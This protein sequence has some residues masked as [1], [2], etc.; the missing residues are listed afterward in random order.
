MLGQP[1]RDAYEVVF[2]Y[3]GIQAVRKDGRKWDLA[4]S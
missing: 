1:V 2:T 3:F 4:V